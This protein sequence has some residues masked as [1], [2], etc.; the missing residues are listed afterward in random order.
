[1]KFVVL[2]N[3]KLLEKGSHEELY[4]KKGKYYSLWQKQLPFYVKEKLEAI[5]D[6]EFWL[7]QNNQS[8][9]KDFILEKTRNN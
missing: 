2:E 5:E 6:Y 7:Q 4:K 1:M 9:D 8:T 3:G